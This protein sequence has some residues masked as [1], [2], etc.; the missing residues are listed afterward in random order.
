MAIEHSHS[1]MSSHVILGDVE[2][3]AN[4]GGLGCEVSRGTEAKILSGMSM[5]YFRL[6]ICGK[7]ACTLLE[8]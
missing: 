2:G 6:R 3:G 4:D 1:L 7:E 5:P 8:P